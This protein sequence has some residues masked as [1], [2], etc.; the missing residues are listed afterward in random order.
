MLRQLSAAYAIVAYPIAYPVTNQTG[1]FQ[2][3]ALL[4]SGMKVC[5]LSCIVH[6]SHS[7]QPVSNCCPGLIHRLCAL[8]TV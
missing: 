2:Q 4:R 8:R 7:P 1:Y 3:S 5:D 6:A